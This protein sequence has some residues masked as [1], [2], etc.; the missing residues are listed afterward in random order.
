MKEIFRSKRLAWNPKGLPASGPYPKLER[1]LQLF[2][3]FIGDWDIIDQTFPRS[4]KRKIKRT[5]E[6]NFNWILNG[7]AV[8]DAWGPINGVTGKYVPVGTTTRFYD[9]SLRAWRSI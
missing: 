1:K 4:D 6:V 8:Q 9:E 5:G 2:G 3:Q 7:M